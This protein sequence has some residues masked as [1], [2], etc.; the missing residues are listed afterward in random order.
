MGSKS[1]SKKIM[2]D[3]NIPVVKGYHGENQDKHF[4]L[5]QAKQ[6]GFPVMIKAVLG[7]GGKGIR[8]VKNESEFFEK[9][10]SC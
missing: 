10:E 6:I 4:L 1:E 3:H 2:E 9:L 8:I 7:G 5:D